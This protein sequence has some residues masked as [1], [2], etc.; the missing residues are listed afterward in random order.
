MEHPVQKVNADFIGGVRYEAPDHR[1]MAEEGLLCADMHFHTNSSDSFTDVGTLLKLA[2]KRGTGLSITDH[3]LISGLLKAEAEKTDVFIVPGIEVSTTDGP[4]IL[5]YFYSLS[6]LEEFWKKEISG[7]LRP[8]PWLALKDCTTVQLLD[9]LEGSNCVVSAAHPMGYFGSNKGA[10]AC[11]RKGYI[12]D[13]TISRMDAYEVLC[14]GMLRENNTDALKAADRHAL[15]YTGGTDGH[16]LNEVGNVVTYSE[17]QDLD[18][19]LDS[20]VKGRAG[21]VGLEKDSQHRVMMGCASFTKFV[22]HGIPAFYTELCLLGPSIRRGL[23]RR[24]G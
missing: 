21:I 8:C 16:L 24:I 4:H 6:E 19:F 17:S 9:R 12:D 23:G 1:G 2:G 11:N 20:I 22:M 14:S 10:E 13:A 3:N 15:K 5:V 18:G 7:R